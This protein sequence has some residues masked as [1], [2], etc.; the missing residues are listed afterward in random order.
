MTQALIDTCAIID[1]PT[2]FSQIPYLQNV[3]SH[4]FLVKITTNFKLENALLAALV[5]AKNVAGWDIIPTK[6]WDG[7]ACTSS[8]GMKNHFVVSEVFLKKKFLTFFANCSL[9]SVKVKL[10]CKE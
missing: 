10:L 6:L 8:P 4:L 9:Q 2:N 3:I 1:E 7:E 5:K